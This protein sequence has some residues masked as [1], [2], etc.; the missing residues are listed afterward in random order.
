MTAPAID[1]SANAWREEANSAA[2]SAGKIRI[3]GE[4]ILAAIRAMSEPDAPSLHAAR[5]Y[6]GHLNTAIPS[7]LYHAG[8]ITG[9]AKRNPTA[10]EA[11]IHIERSA[12][13]MLSAL[14]RAIATLQSA[15]IELTHNLSAIMAS[16]EIEPSATTSQ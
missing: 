14:R 1:K 10:E 4:K 3:A 11:P 9:W 2:Q 16:A 12:E 7:V 8:T 13:E 6:N 15:H 5:L